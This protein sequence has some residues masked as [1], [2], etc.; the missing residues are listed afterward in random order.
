MS[1]FR[2]KIRW[3]IPGELA[4][5]TPPT[6]GGEQPAAPSAPETGADFS[7]IP[8]DFHVDGKPDLG[9]FTAHYQELVATDAQRKQAMA[10][11]PQDGAYDF[12]LPPDLKFDGLDLPE[13]FKVELATDD[14][15]MKPLFDELGSVMKE[16]GLPKAAAGKFTSLLAKYEATKTSQYFAAAKQ[17]EAAV[18]QEMSALGSEAQAIARLQTIERKLQ[19]MLPADQVD[20]LK[21]ATTSAK[22]VM[23]LEKLLS[24]SGL[25]S[26]VA[27]PPASKVDD[28]V[29]YYSTPTKRG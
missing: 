29:A 3:Q 12:A 17:Q 23:A 13:G 10:D 15:A 2:D 11:V 7:F 19:T 27:Q 1:K 4:G 24:P 25:S 8:Q 14:P 21:G 9:K 5:S 16:L 26:P 6:A 22:A 20:A 28:L 18:K